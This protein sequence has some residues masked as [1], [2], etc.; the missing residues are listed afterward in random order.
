MQSG[1]LCVSGPMHVA[2]ASCL[3]PRPC[4][5]VTFLSLMLMQYLVDICNLHV[6]GAPYA[7]SK[8]GAAPSVSLDSRAWRVNYVDGVVIT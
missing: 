5:F 8:D 6:I 4:G 1:F 7:D 3:P 2:S